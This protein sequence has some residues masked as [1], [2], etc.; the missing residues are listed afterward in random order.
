MGTFFLA[1]TTNESAKGII[2]LSAG[3][4]SAIAPVLLGFSLN[5]LTAFSAKFLMGVSQSI[6][7]ALA[8]TYVQ[9][10]T[11]DRLRGRI[12]SLYILHAGG[13]MAF[14]NLGYGNLADIFGAPEILIVTGVIFLAIF[15]G[16]SSSDPIL[17][18]VYK[19][20]KL[21]SIP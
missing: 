11:P 6:F 8:M 1:G 9:T 10:G 7:M 2:L 5:I 14:A 4:V 19:G 18:S 15:I 3:L 16:L 13:I 21:Q 17:K 20:R 12:S